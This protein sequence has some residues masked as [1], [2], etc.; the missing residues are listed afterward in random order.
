M[1]Y[2]YIPLVK[3]QIPLWSFQLKQPQKC[4]LAFPLIQDYTAKDD[5]RPPAP[6]SAAEWPNQVA[7]PPESFCPGSKMEGG[8]SSSSAPS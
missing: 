5:T 1:L 2:S 4:V 6:P 8:N 3:G 7:L